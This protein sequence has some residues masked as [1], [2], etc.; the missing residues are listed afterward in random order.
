ME[1]WKALEMKV[2]DQR[3]ARKV[4]FPT[5]VQWDPHPRTQLPCGLSS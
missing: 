5:P 3:A 1:E 4:S 2:G